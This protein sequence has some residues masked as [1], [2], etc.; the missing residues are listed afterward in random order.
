[1]DWTVDWTMDRV[2]FPLVGCLYFPLTTDAYRRG[3]EEPAAIIDYAICEHNNEPFA[4][5]LTDFSVFPTET[6]L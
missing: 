2:Q 5:D 3:T 1:M 6:V 4:P